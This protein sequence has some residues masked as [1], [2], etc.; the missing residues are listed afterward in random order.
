MMLWA[1]VL[2]SYCAEA[3]PKGNMTS[4]PFVQTVSLFLFFIFIFL[5]FK[6]APV[7]YGGSQARGQIGAADAGHATAIAM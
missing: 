4:L 7:V 5:L 6:A 3:K 1:G 2:C